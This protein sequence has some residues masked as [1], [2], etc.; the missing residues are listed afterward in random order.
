MNTLLAAVLTLP[1][2]PQATTVI[3]NGP[4]SLGG[5]WDGEG[6]CY[7]GIVWGGESW[8]EPEVGKVLRQDLDFFP[9]VRD[10]CASPLILYIHPPR[11]TK[12]IDPARGALYS[13]LVQQARANG[14]SVASVEY[15]QPVW[16]DLFDPA[17]DND[18][19]A[20]RRWVHAHAR[21]LG[22]DLGNVFF[23]DQ[24]R[25]TLGL[26]TALQHRNDP[27]VRVNAAYSHHQRTTFRGVEVAR[28]FV[29]ESDGLGFVDRISP[30]RAYD[31]VIPF[32][33]R[34]L[35]A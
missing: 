18:I 27:A 26:R 14:F 9:V 24:S 29:A 28:R 11:D 19:A 31:G 35:R 7:R 3:P 20:A 30:E 21:Q 33:Q 32:F 4:A 6:Y 1:A 10:Q 23:V 25:G 34:Y 8:F 13:R 5:T 17:P 16:D 2:L 12:M 15:R 22:V